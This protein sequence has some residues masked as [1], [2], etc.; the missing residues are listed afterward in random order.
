[1][2]KAGRIGWQRPGGISPPCP[3]PD[4]GKWHGLVG[5]VE[6]W[7]PEKQAQY[8]SLG[9]LGAAIPSLHHSTTPFRSSNIPTLSFELIRVILR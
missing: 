2:D 8:W 9:V 3:V 5:V 1:M 6:W 4:G 7:T